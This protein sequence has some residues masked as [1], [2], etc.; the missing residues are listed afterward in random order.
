MER[1]GAYHVEVDVVDDLVSNSA[2]VL[3]QVVVL[4]PR[5]IDELL[6]DGLCGL[7]WSA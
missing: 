1:A 4:C 6:D 5:S 7:N 3:Q 2:V